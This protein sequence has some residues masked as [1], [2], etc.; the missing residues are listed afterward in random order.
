MAGHSKWNNI[1]RR[2]GAQDAARGRI[3]TKL[4]RE[5]QMAVKAGGPNPEINASLR[6]VIAKA[7]ASNMPNDNINRSIARAS[8]Q[9]ADELEVILYEGY[10]PSGVAV[11]VR[12]LSDNRN[13]TAGD[14]R[15]IFDRSGGNMG[16]TGCVAFQFEEKGSLLLDRER[17]ADEDQL[18]MDA[19]ELGAEDVLSEAEG[20]EVVTSP[21]DYRQVKDGLESQGYVFEDASLGP[22]PLTMVDLKGE[23][24]IKQMEKM[25][26]A[27]DDND[28]VSEVWHNWEQPEA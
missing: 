28:D 27:F 13:R 21:E 14:L 17:Y 9:G 26:D 10:G 16:N 3:F 23:D 8:G 15:H 19:L 24:E 20:F 25:L 11:M 12:C 6:D 2:K 4:G 1:K 7:K 22:V 5:I 18:M